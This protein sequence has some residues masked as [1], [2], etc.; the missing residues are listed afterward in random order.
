VTG[1]RYLV[2]RL[3]ALG[4][5]AMSSSLIGAIRARAPDAHVT[6]LC[7]S[8]V[9]E[10]VAM[11]DGVDEMIVADEVA[12]L[13]G[14]LRARAGALLSLWR[15]LALRRYDVTLL[16]H[17][18]RRYRALL[19]VVRTGRLR[20]L[21]HRVSPGM[22]PIP[23]RYLGDELVRLLEEGPAVGP[24]A[25]QF[26]L[27]DLRGRVSLSRASARAGIVL[28]PGGTRNVLREDS[29]RRWPVERYREV[30]S[31]LLADGHTVTL[32]GDEGDSWVRPSFAGLAIRDEI[33]AH[34]VAGTLGIL[35]TASLV[36]AHDTGLL[37]LA[38]LVRTPVLALFG[39]TMPSKAIAQQADVR[40]L[41]GGVD[42]A[43]RP[44][45]NGRDFARCS[46]NRCMQD[47]SV[48]TVLAAVRELH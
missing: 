47:I 6:W 39:P 30:A 38:R 28:G 25:R 9:A 14:S 8:R 42:L 29:L 48:D 36:I 2:V 37:H 20:S 21:D 44:C 26:P 13:R 46:D 7:G 27:A 34:S 43:C 41:W 17:E 22:L 18:D 35:G 16:G 33:G 12:L 19:A 40:V 1:A 45:Y 4:D 10:L 11:F 24:V 23:G 5:V 15:R 31:R 3:G 32:A